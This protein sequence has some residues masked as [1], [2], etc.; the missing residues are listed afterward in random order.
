MTP[1]ELLSAFF[2]IAGVSFFIFGTVG[3]IRFPDVFSRLHALTKADNLGLGFIIGGLLLQNPPLA[4]VLKLLLVWIFAIISSA[5]ASY[6]VAQAARR[7]GIEPWRG[8]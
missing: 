5:T 2:L 3:L 6:L 7:M 1:V 4:V 8:E